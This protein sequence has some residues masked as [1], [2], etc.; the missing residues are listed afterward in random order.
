[1][2]C[3]E[4]L[5]SL[6]L[7][8]SPI[9]FIIIIFINYAITLPPAVAS[10]EVKTKYCLLLLSCLSLWKHEPP[11]V[12]HDAGNPLPIVSYPGMSLRKHVCSKPGRHLWITGWLKC[13]RG[14]SSGGLAWKERVYGS[15]WV[16]PRFWYP[17]QDCWAPEVWQKSQYRVS[18]V[19]A[20]TP[21]SVTVVPVGSTRDAVVSLAFSYKRC[22][23][24]SWPVD[25]RPMTE[26]TKGR[27][28]S[29]ITSAI[30]LLSWGLLI[31]MWLLWT[32]FHHKNGKTPCSMERMQRALAHPHLPISII[33]R[34]RVY[35]SHVRSAMLHAMKAWYSTAG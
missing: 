33:S 14:W 8:R 27:Y 26:I 25:G 17:D 10:I 4:Y 18:W 6:V 15:P 2:F 3:S 32:R 12:H 5:V 29:L 19:S 24:L 16:K 34:N 31:L 1:M 30:L 11:T 22:T 35:D 20:Q 9:V 21:S 23:G 7:G 28:R 13:K